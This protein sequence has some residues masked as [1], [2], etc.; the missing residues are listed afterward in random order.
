MPK[1][2][3]GPTKNK[4]TDYY[5][6]DQIVGIGK[7]KKR[8]RYSLKTKDPEKAHWL[9][10]QEYRKRWSEYYGIQSPMRARHVRFSYMAEEFVDYEK[11][12]KRI[13]EWKIQQ[14]RLA[15][16]NNLWENP[17]LRDIGKDYLIQ[18]DEY[19][20]GQGRS[21]TTVNHYFTLLK[22]LF[23]YAIKQK[24]LSENPVK[25]IIPYTVDG[26]RRE[27]S[28]EEIERILVAADH[29]E[30]IAR[31]GSVV[32]KYAKRIVLLLL[33]TGMRT[34]EL[35]RLRWDN[36][37]DDKIV[38]KRTET[39]QKKEKVIPLTDGIREVLESMRDD[40]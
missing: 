34:E 17:N 11:N 15:I 25:E 20:I 6:F 12:I 39:K 40:R 28:P 31:R 1:C 2:C 29:I 3:E 16:I 13:K 38:L 9:W 14:D 18:L 7:E 10:E 4:Q 35:L 19:L 32:Q 21:K 26:K 30:K 37:K 33:Y 24:Y 23:N 8:Y 27:Y 36:I 22:S 5:Y